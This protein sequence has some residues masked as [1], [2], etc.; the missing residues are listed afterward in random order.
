VDQNVS[1]DERQRRAEALQ[2]LSE[3]FLRTA[4]ETKN[5]TCEDTGASAEELEE[6]ITKALKMAMKQVRSQ[7]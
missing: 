6:H 2:I 5:E 4:K 7:D 1:P 3:E